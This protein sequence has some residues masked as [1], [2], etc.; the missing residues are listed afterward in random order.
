M[1]KKSYYSKYRRKKTSKKRKS[2]KRSSSKKPIGYVKV[3][4]G[5]KLVYGTKK[6]PKLGKGKYSKK[7]TLLDKARKLLSK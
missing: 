3:K 7:K 1:P 6:N 2:K 5:Y 4:G